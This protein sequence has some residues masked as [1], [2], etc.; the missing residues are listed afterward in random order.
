[1]NIDVPQMWYTAQVLH[2]NGAT[3]TDVLGKHIIFSPGDLHVYIKA[4]GLSKC[5]R[6]VQRSG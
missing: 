6:P 2:R 4:L 1:M 3:A 5:G